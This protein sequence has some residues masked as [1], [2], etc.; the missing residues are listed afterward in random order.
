M[1]RLAMLLPLVMLCAAAAEKVTVVTEDGIVVQGKML[2]CDDT[3]VTIEVPLFGG[4]TVPRETI[5]TIYPKGATVELDVEKAA[6]REIAAEHQ[7][8]DAEKA[9]RQKAMTLRELPEERPPKE[10]VT[11]SSAASAKPAKTA[12]SKKAE[13]E[14]T[15]K[16]PDKTKKTGEPPAKKPAPELDTPKKGPATLDLPKKLLDAAVQLLETAPKAAP[17]VAPKAAPVVAPALAPAPAPAPAPKPAP[18]APAPE[19]A[20]KQAPPQAPQAPQAPK[21]VPPVN[22]PIVQ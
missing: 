5:K 3:T 20:P 19:Q 12:A 7:R 21:A 18:A 9:E 22:A 6:I 8:L 14:E 13:G 1:N 2:R 10:G 16:A 4:R 17:P 11:S 15:P